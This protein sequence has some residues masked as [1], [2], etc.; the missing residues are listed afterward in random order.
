M[1]YRP[2]LT[3]PPCSAPFRALRQSRSDSSSLLQ[4]PGWERPRGSSPVDLLIL[5]ATCEVVS[6]RISGTER[7]FEQLSL[8]PLMDRR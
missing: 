4:L 5:I 2:P 3:L 1:C 6:S 8:L 7:G